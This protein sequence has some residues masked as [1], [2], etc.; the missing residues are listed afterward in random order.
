MKETEYL[1]SMDR[2]KRLFYLNFF[3][4]RIIGAFQEKTAQNTHTCTGTEDPGPTRNL[5]QAGLARP[6]N[7]Q[8]AGGSKNSLCRPPNE[9]FCC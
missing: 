5:P 1:Y 6:T 7:F 4:V 3:C 2:E 8:A 9:D